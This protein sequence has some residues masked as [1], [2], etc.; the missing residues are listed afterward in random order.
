MVN[1]FLEIA[2]LPPVSRRVPRAVAVAAGGVLEAVY[3]AFRLPGEPRMTRFL[4]R[5]LSTAH[6]YNLD[7]ARRDL[8]YS[9]AVGIEEGLQRL[10]RS[11]RGKV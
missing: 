9:P 10:A 1:R 11:L 8:G 6:W 5:E 3:A 4:A 7:A 2:G